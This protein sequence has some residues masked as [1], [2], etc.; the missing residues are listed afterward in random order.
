MTLAPYQ[1]QMTGHGGSMGLA[2][3]AA[4]RVQTPA[5]VTDDT[6]VNSG[7][8]QPL[9]D[10]F[11]P[12]STGGGLNR[13]RLFSHSFALGL[14]PSSAF[15][16]DRRLAGPPPVSRH[17]FR[18]P[19]VGVRRGGCAFVAAPTALHFKPTNHVCQ[20]NS[21]WSERHLQRAFR[22]RSSMTNHHPKG[23]EA[24]SPNRGIPLP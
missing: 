8:L 13:S 17:P 22:G 12:V 5:I 24:C 15:E 4:N 20:D 14:C 3:C 21:D 6:Q 11:L 10:N 16:R 2:P 7:L 18:S 9:F 23:S 19:R 1:S